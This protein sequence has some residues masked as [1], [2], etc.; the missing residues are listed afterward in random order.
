MEEARTPQP[1]DR[2]ETLE[3]VTLAIHPGQ[4]VL[5]FSPPRI[6]GA[7][8]TAPA[9]PL[10]TAATLDQ[11]HSTSLHL[12]AGTSQPSPV[13]LDPLGAGSSQNPLVTQAPGPSS[14]P[15]QSALLAQV[16]S[17]LQATQATVQSM[18]EDAQRHQLE[19]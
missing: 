6:G 1:R 19:M 15:D 4:G 8:G 14:Q 10:P 7:A 16:L 13:T 5:G 9:S 2:S 17:A 11:H 18:R 12:G 3:E